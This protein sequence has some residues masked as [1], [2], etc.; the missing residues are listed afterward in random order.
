MHHDRRHAL[1]DSQFHLQCQHNFP[2][3]W[4]NMC[5]TPWPLGTTCSNGT[6]LMECWKPSKFMLDKLSLSDVQG[7]TTW[8]SKLTVGCW[9]YSCLKLVWA[10]LK[11]SFETILAV[12]ERPSGAY[13]LLAAACLER[14]VWAIWAQIRPLPL[15]DACQL[16]ARHTVCNWGRYA[17]D[18]R[19]WQGNTMM[20]KL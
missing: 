8:S 16:Q 7:L 9:A 20:Q 13:L 19:L 15:P 1:T 17:K 2:T 3:A 10:F 14:H 12:S 4:A 6:C 18:K 11:V 5:D